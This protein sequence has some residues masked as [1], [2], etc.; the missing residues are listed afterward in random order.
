MVLLLLRT[1]F[2]DEKIIVAKDL[3]WN[4]TNSGFKCMVFFESQARFSTQ[5]F[6]L[7]NLAEQI[8]HQYGLLLQ[9]PGL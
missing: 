4:K 9:I 7:F 5:V 8:L 3:N 1:L 6:S 2:Q